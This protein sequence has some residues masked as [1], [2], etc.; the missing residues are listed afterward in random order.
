MPKLD[1]EKE[2]G[3]LKTCK[4]SGGAICPV[5]GAGEPDVLFGDKDESDGSI[6]IEFWNCEECGTTYEIRWIV[7]GVSIT[8]RGI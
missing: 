3:F 5:C 8:D 2:R 4:Q 1:I 6:K 7:N